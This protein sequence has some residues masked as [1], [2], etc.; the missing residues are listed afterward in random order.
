MKDERLSEMK[1]DYET[2]PIPPELKERITD[3]MEWAKKDVAFT[4]KKSS[5]LLTFQDVS[6]HFVSAAATILL[7]ITVL[8]N[9][10]RSIAYA[11]EEIPFLG[12]IARIVT[13]REYTD[14]QNHMEANVKVPAVSVEDTQGNPLETATENFNRQIEAYTNQIIDAYEKDAAISGEEGRM[15]LNLDY[16]IITDNERIF[17]LRFDQVMV[18]AG[19]M[20]AVQIYNLDKTTGELLSLGNLF[21]EGS[22]YIT[23]ISDFLKEQMHNQMAADEDVSYFYETDME[24]L[25]FTAIRPNENFYISKEGKLTLVFDKYE[26]APG[27]MGSV[28]FEIPTEVIAAIVKDGFVK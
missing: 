14:S 11:M 22:D 4:S 28:E 18:M 2:I 9:S 17:A 27:Y 25:N 21:E 24:E 26:I 13:F 5:W 1:H 19:T 3:T 16:E 10:G 15:A 8:A 7:L 20:H 12:A 6:L 23:P